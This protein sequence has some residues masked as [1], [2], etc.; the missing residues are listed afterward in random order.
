MKQAIV[1]IFALALCAFSV[2]AQPVVIDSLHKLG[3]EYA[4]KDIEKQKEIIYKGITLSKRQNSYKLTS[5]YSLLTV[6]H[7]NVGDLDSAKV[8]LDILEDLGKGGDEEI[9]GNYYHTA[10]LFWKNQGKPKE[11]LPFMVKSLELTKDST[12]R[13]GMML[14]IGNTYKEL[15]ELKE[16]VDYHLKSLSLFEKVGNKKGQAF[17]YNSLGSDYIGMQQ[18]EKAGVYYDKSLKLKEELKD[19]RGMITTLGGLGNVKMETGEYKAAIA[20]FEKELD[21]ANEMQT[22]IDQGHAFHHLGQVYSRMKENDKSRNYYTQAL[23]FA[24]QV[25]DEAWTAW[26]ESNIQKL[27]ED[28]VSKEI[29][30]AGL[31]KTLRQYE[32]MGDRIGVANSLDN[33]ASFYSDQKEYEKA[34]SNLRRS[35]ILNDSARGMSVDEQLRK[36]EDQYANEK[37]D[38]EI[39]LLRKDQELKTADLER[40]QAV[41]AGIIIALISVLVIGG[42]LVN[43]YQVISRGKRLAEI[44]KVRNA[45]ARDLHDDIGSTLSSINILSQLAL[46]EGNDGALKHFSKIAE[47]SSRM[48]ESMSDIVWS[49]SPGNDSLEQVVSKMKEFA[50]EILEPKNITYRFS[51]EDS[52]K[53]TTLSLD[54]RKNLFLIFKEA[55]NNAAKYS[56]AT[57]LEITFARQGNTLSL[58]VSDNGGGFELETVKPG[59]GLKNMKERARA[60]SARFDFVTRVKEGTRIALELPLT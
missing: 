48:M 55:V 15:G 34:Y 54:K 28:K 10:G 52:L 8:Y 33:L 9:R 60:L 2:N 4:R 24:K 49:I 6:A 40:K 14:N 27:D 1:A 13:A 32:E 37:R 41:Q 44:E 25:K 36:L 57:D 7:Q 35:Q 20:A 39:A 23:V 43:R 19:K 12:N 53:N 51:G 17:A 56:G 50:A 26:I 5:F 47:Q 22:P 21:F 59:N 30:E 3:L 42:L 16:A 29:L 58:S 38:R 45:I 18:W 46:R 11:A 31:L